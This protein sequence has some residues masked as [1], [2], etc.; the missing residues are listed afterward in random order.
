MPD[1]TAVSPENTAEQ[2]DR[3]GVELPQAK[4]QF[5]GER[6]GPGMTTLPWAVQTWLKRSRCRLGCG[7]GWAQGSIM[8]HGVHIGVIWRIQV[9]RPC[10]SGSNKAAAMWPYI[11]LLWPPVNTMISE[12][13]ASSLGLPVSTLMTGKLSTV[14]C[15]LRQV[16]NAPTSDSLVVSSLDL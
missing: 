9:N 4:G 16:V 15:S 1:D 5:L 13:S 10:S 3:R 7:L 12:I 11:T 14:T 8:L 6:T 2:I